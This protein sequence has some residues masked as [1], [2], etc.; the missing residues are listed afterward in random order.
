LEKDPLWSQINSKP[1]EFVRNDKKREHFRKCIDNIVG[2]LITDVDA[3]IEGAGPDFDYRDKLRDADWVQ[4]LAR[5]VVGDHIKMVT[6][7]KIQS[8]KDDWEKG[9][10]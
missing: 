5:T 6:R 2:D 9:I 7:K 1:E 3:E 4:Q 10:K 8:F